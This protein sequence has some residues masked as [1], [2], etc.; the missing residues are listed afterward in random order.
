MP[1]C[2]AKAAAPVKTQVG[3]RLLHA[4][5]AAY[6]RIAVRRCTELEMYASARRHEGNVAANARREIKGYVVP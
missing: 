3:G 2:R 4:T 5:N 6:S 1:A